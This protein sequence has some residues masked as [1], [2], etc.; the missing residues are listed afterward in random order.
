MFLFGFVTGVVCTFVGGIVSIIALASFLAIK[1]VK[2]RKADTEK[3]DLAPTST[4]GRDG[5]LKG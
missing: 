3:D 4:Y 2:G 5:N 1:D